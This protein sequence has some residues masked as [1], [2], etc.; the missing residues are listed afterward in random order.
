MKVQD[1]LGH[2][3]ISQDAGWYSVGE[4]RGGAFRGYD[5]LVTTFLPALER[6]GFTQD[7]INQLMVVNPAKAFA[8][9]VRAS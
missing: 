7:E 6:E 1:L 3:L 2:V 9:Q 4:E 8:I 5:Y